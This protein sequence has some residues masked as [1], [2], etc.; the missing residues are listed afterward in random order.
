MKTRLPQNFKSLLWSYD[1]LKFDPDKDRE[2]LIINTINYGD[3]EHWQWIFRQYTTY[4]IKKIIANIPA[5]E[6]RERTLKL[7][8]LLLNIKKIKYASRSIKIR[9][10]KNI[11]QP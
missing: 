10:A 9:A 3:W 2:R 8:R 5:S 4:G 6:F 7:V 1:F 11:T